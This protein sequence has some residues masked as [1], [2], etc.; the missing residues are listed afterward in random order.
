MAV[1]L[2]PLVQSIVLDPSGVMAGAGQITKGTGQMNTGFQKSNKVLA[3]TNNSLNTMAFRAQTTGRNLFKFIGAPLL[4]IG[5]AS[6]TAF[7]KFESSMMKIEALV[8]VSTGAVN[9]FGDAVK[10][11]SRITGRGPQELADAMF[12][13]AS[14]GLRGATA[15]EVLEASAKGAAVGLGQTK[16][17]ADAATSAVNAY[18]AEN[19]SGSAA[20]DVL[21]AAVREGKVEADRLA[22]A[23][24]KA[25]PVASAMGIEFHEVAAAIAAM[26]RTGTDART[27]AIQL[28]QIMQSILDPSRQTEAALRGMGI[29]QGELAD[30][31]RSDGLLAVLKR[32]RDL[33]K[34]NEQ[35]FA[36]IFPNI[37]ALAGAM[38]ITGENL[39]ENETI[40]ASL[41]NSAGDTDKAF[42]KVSET[43]EF[44]F[45]KAMQGM[46]T[47]FIELG[48]AMQPLLVV[49]TKFLDTI[50]WLFRVIGSNPV[51]A[52]LTIAVGGLATAMGLLL[53]VAGR[54]AQAMVFYQLATGKAV[55]A[56]F[57]MTKATN[58]LTIALLKN[59]LFLGITAVVGIA[60]LT[61]HLGIFGKSAKTAAH[62][63]ADAQGQIRDVKN[64]A[65]LSVKPMHDFADAIRSVGEASRELEIAKDFMSK[66]EDIIKEAR[67]IGDIE[68]T[69]TITRSLIS[70]FQ[71]QGVT[72]ENRKAIEAVLESI[73]KEF[74]ETADDI[75]TPE[76][77]GKGLTTKEII[78]QLLGGGEFAADAD[79][80]A[81][82]S[83][84]GDE[85]MDQTKD[86][87]ADWQS[88]TRGQVGFGLNLSDFVQTK[89]DDGIEE[90]LS[91]PVEVFLQKMNAGRFREAFNI[92]DEIRGAI[93][94][95][96]EGDE[97]IAMLALVDKAFADKLH[98]I[99][100]FTQDMGKDINSIDQMM[101]ILM[102]GEESGMLTGEF[103][104]D[105]WWHALADEMER[106]QATLTHGEMRRVMNG[107]ITLSELVRNKAIANLEAVNEELKDLGDDGPDAIQT[108]GNA[109]KDLE[110]AMGVVDDKAKEFGDRFDLLTERG[111]ALARV[112]GNVNEAIG[113]FGEAA[114]ESGGQ[115]DGFGGEATDTLNAFL[116]AIEEM[117]DAGTTMVASGEFTAEE[118]ANSVF[119]MVEV[120]KAEARALGVAEDVMADL[121]HGIGMGTESA[122]TEVLAAGANDPLSNELNTRLNN[123]LDNAKNILDFSAGEVMGTDFFRG[124]K[125]GMIIGGKEVTNVMR[126]QIQGILDAGKDEGEIDSPSKLFAREMGNPIA[127]GIALGILEKQ[128]AP[129]NAIRKVVENIISEVKGKVGAVTNAMGA[130]LDFAD[131]KR[132]L[133]KAA[134]DFGAGGVVTRRERLTQAQ[135]QRDVRDAERALRL[136]QGHQTDLEL[137]LLDAQDAL[138]DYESVI[139][140]EGPVAKAQVDLME[141]GLEVAESQA[142]MKMA[143]DEAI[144]AFTTLSEAIG[145]QLSPELQGLIGSTESLV[146][147]TEQNESLFQDMFGEN[148]QTWIQAVADGMVVIAEEAEDAGYH[149]SNYV[150]SVNEAGEIMKNMASFDG[151][152]GNWSSANMAGY[153]NY[154]PQTGQNSPYYNFRHLSGLD[155]AD[156]KYLMGGY[157]NPAQ[158][159]AVGGVNVN[160]EVYIDENGTDTHTSTS[161]MDTQGR[162]SSAPSETKKHDPVKAPRYGRAGLSWG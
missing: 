63:L 43:A 113:D 77:F 66:F 120:L 162:L 27:S 151:M 146:A 130:A 103:G 34:D 99:D 155:P 58:G 4:A 51:F 67:E 70:V 74:G 94:D 40:F 82:M 10:N 132:A 97:E 38:D 19:L 114:F 7:A 160:T 119:G 15:M 31:A 39:Q 159:A 65:M 107:D 6:L 79:I 33:S 123:A 139:T 17:V 88:L 127:E 109:F 1:Q 18:G 5:A 150:G 8:G 21:T 30:Q 42:E 2:P 50:S 57:A 54:A 90:A 55:G 98:R 72:E 35:A 125:E 22:P 152:P 124:M 73:E 49:I 161:I 61:K 9:Q 68:G 12:F 24:G 153:R 13:V 118:A 44:K 106:V 105:K 129:Q 48:A 37:R 3:E 83:G 46:K 25:I 128:K 126:E 108:V 156:F 143:G 101:A 53:I 76:I 137:A 14:A 92:I 29:A 115:M 140:S 102:Q 89:D 136:G 157:G 138:A 71:G 85:L 111:I 147:I 133:A 154:T 86:L 142:A 84:I 145:M 36:D 112:Q 122:L 81:L 47:S 11:A 141:S 117:R 69:S 52:T 64:I 41:A 116:D 95:T 91:G 121:L 149:M 135:L 78:D 100:G 110:A 20:V 26:T 60:L 131:A 158:Q 75:F 96:A 23:I 28:R 80:R 45:N 32:L 62:E 148:V 59:P 93:R 87:V 56:T 16:V 144:T 134:R 104:G